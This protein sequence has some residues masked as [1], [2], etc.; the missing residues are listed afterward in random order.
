MSDGRKERASTASA[1]LARTA[2]QAPGMAR[3]A[4][5]AARQMMMTP[6]PTRAAISRCRSA[7]STCATAQ[8]KTS[9]FPPTTAPSTNTEGSTPSSRPL[10]R[11]IAAKATNHH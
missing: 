1:S 8:A 2:F 5:V 11:P 7:H 4:A 10:S 3:F 6:A 9:P